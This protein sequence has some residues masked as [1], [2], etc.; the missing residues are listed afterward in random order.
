MTLEDLGWTAGFAA[1]FAPHREAGLE[2]AR[3]SLEHTHIYRVITPG[4]ERLARVAGRLRHAAARRA[5]FPAV[6]DWVALE[7]AAPG[8]EARIRAVLPRATHFSRRAAG[9]PTEEQVVAANID[10]VFLVSGLDHD[11]NPRRIERYLVTA[12]ESGAAPVVVLNKADLV[13]DPGAF[14]AQVAAI[15][16]DV[17]VLTVSAKTPASLDALRARLGRGRTAALLGSSGVGKSSIANGLIGEAILRTHEV[18]TSDSRG[19]HTTTGRQLVLLPGGGILIDTPGMR[20]LQLWEAAEPAA[21]AFSDIAA[22]ADHCRFRDCR[23]LSEPG[24][25]VVAAAAGGTLAQGRLASFRKLQ[26]EQTFLASQQD[27]RARIEQ[28][29]AGRIGAKALR[30]RVR[31][32]RG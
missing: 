23:H 15:A 19:R 22:L 13:E 25:A 26:D 21:T 9:D 31:D 11:F 7:A 1:A 8:H 30:K 12:W 32:K 18:R 14:A 6:G 10:V 3:V 27:E 16:P 29:R 17:P 5:D 28:K 2:P 24:C 4:G 20:E